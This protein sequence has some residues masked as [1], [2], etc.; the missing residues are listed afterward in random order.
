MVLRTLV[1]VLLAFAGAAVAQTYPQRAVK[2]LIPFPPGG[3]PDLTAR[4]LATR[5]S[6]RLG[7]PFVAENRVGAGGNIAA[8]AVAKS[9][10]DGYTLFAG[11]DGPLVINPNVYAHVGFDTLHDFAPISIATSSGFVLM[12][13]DKVPANS[14]SELIALAKTR[15]LSIGSSGF[16]SNHHLAAEMLKSAGGVEITHVPYKGF[17]NA[18]VDAVACNV[19]L[20]FGSISAAI[21][22]IKSGKLKGLAVTQSARHPQL[23]ETPTFAEAGY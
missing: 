1:A 9:P 20:L 2:V 23:P 5:L 19:D 21:P 15:K 16:G 6:E 14:V 7:Q 3:A 17:G 11:S 10:P 18:V 12:A 8:E 4:I 22:Y 13:C